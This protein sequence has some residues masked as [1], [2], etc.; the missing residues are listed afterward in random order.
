[1]TSP[2]ALEVVRASYTNNGNNIGNNSDELPYSP[3]QEAKDLYIQDTRQIMFIYKIMDNKRYIVAFDMETHDE[4]PMWVGFQ[5]GKVGPAIFF[6]PLYSKRTMT[7]IIAFAK[8]SDAKVQIPFT[9]SNGSGLFLEKTSR[10]KLY[11]CADDQESS[12]YYKRNT[13]TDL[14]TTS[15]DKTKPI[16]S[17]YVW[18]NSTVPRETGELFYTIDDDNSNKKPPASAAVSE[19]RSSDDTDEILVSVAPLASKRTRFD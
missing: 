3:P 1:M 15:P 4:I 9:G 10:I 18:K 19:K 13:L 16:I 8:T 14:L 12:E 17:A 2:A 5:K 7:Q 11:L 6:L